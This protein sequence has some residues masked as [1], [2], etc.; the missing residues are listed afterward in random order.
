VAE[1]ARQQRL[2]LYRLQDDAN[3]S[4]WL[5]A[6]LLSALHTAV[7][8]AISVALQQ[9]QQ[10]SALTD[11]RTTAAAAAAAADRGPAGGAISL[12]AW[13]QQQAKECAVSTTQA[14]LSGLYG[15]GHDFGVSCC[16]SLAA[17]PTHTTTAVI[18]KP[19]SGESAAAK[20]SSSSS[21]RRA[22]SSLCVLGAVVSILEAAC[23]DSPDQLLLGL[24]ASVAAGLSAGILEALPP[25]ATAVPAAVVPQ[26][27]HAHFAA[28]ADAAW[29]GLSQHQQRRPATSPHARHG[30]MQGQGLGTALAAAGAAA[31]LHRPSR[32]QQLLTEAETLVSAVQTACSRCHSFVSQ[33][34]WDTPETAEAAAA[35]AA[36]GH[37][38]LGQA[39]GRLMLAYASTDH[40][41]VHHQQRHQQQQWV[42]SLPGLL[43]GLQYL[44]DQCCSM[45]GVFYHAAGSHNAA[46]ANSWLAQHQL[47]HPAQEVGALARGL[48]AA[49]AQ[50]AGKAA[51]DPAAQAAPQQQQLLQVLVALRAAGVKLARSYSNYLLAT[52]A[53]VLGAVDAAAVRQQLDRSFATHLA[54]LTD[55]WQA[56]STS[57]SSSGSSS[58]PSVSNRLPAAAAAEAASTSR[59]VEA[60]AA[61]AG[62]AAGPAAA[63]LQAALVAISLADLAA[64]QF[65]RVQLP[66]Y[67]DLLR[68]L[69]TAL[70]T[71]T[72]AADAFIVSALPCYERL[73]QQQPGAMS[74]SGSSSSSRSNN[75]DQALDSTSGCDK[76]INASPEGPASAVWLH[77]NVTAAELSFLLPLLPVSVRAA[78]N[79]AAAAEQVL[80][81]LLLL[82][83]HPLTGVAQAAHASFAGLVAIAAEQQRSSLE[84]QQRTAA[85]SSEAHLLQEMVPHQQKLQV[86][87]VVVR[88]VPM[89]LQRTL[90]ALPDYGSTE[91]LSASYYSLLKNLP[92]GSAMGLLAISKLADRALQLATAAT[93]ADADYVPNLQPGSSTKRSVLEGPT[94]SAQEAPASTATAAMNAAGKLL[95]L[96]VLSIQIGDY[97]L[98]PATLKA[99]ASCVLDAPFSVQVKWLPQLYT[100]CLA[101]GDYT[102]KTALMAWVDEVQG[103]LQQRQQQRRQQLPVQSKKEPAEP[104]AQ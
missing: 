34:A 6:S 64:L 95:E 63:D 37:S 80:P 93:M 77:D 61:A 8:S 51:A 81:V 73:V 52:P 88:A 2:P 10:G 5:V 18:P 31:S 72:S 54:I 87:D 41:S 9:V 104:L 19:W 89:Y 12:H 85:A 86:M 57:S 15:L 58:D 69:V 39:Y 16:R 11:Q 55:V 76:S 97:Q 3:L 78:S 33:A 21:S 13:L 30:S 96:L 94:G 62:D 46:A 7:P 82:L 71:S 36:V 26:A 44:T 35:A 83:P 43:Y 45:A 40:Q 56:C 14:L 103:R 91:G 60:A 25:P 1:A 27:N 17:Q 66:A 50:W 101:V 100:G 102:R 75:A 65:C 22:D 59:G 53:A 99:V 74:L 68:G 20:D 47:Q 67:V 23:K 29:G 48:A 24:A 4:A 38:L 79:A 28:A 90:A 92:S 49:T 42:N 32:R 98:L 84:A 70:A